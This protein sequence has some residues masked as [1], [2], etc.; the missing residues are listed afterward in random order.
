MGFMLLD[1]PRTDN[2]K[3]NHMTY[4]IRTDMNE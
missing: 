2:N 3:R 4:N 1:I